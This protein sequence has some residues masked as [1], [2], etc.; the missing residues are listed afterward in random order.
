MELRAE[1]LSLQE[2]TEID[3]ATVGILSDVAVSIASEQAC[4]LLEHGGAKVDYK[5]ALVKIREVLFRNLSV[6]N[7][8]VL[9]P[10][11]S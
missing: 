4:G 8:S 9:Q 3:R 7:L 2:V 10:R 6:G 5:S 11:P 1:I